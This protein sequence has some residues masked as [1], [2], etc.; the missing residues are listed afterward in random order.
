MLSFFYYYILVQQWILVRQ[1]PA[2]LE[3]PELQNSLQIDDCFTSLNH[4]LIRLFFLTRILTSLEN[5]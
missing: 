1:T 3:A 2:S 4:L 5:F